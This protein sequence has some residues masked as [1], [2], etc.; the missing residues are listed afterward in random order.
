MTTGTATNAVYN[1]ATTRKGRYATFAAREREMVPLYT[2]IGPDS[3]QVNIQMYD[4]EQM[5][6]NVTRMMKSQKAKTSRQRHRPCL[7]RRAH[8]SGQPGQ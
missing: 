3:K 4:P 5:V 2:E 6:K 8:L 1:T 7:R